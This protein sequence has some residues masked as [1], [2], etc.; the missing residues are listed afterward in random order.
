[1]IGQFADLEAEQ[2]IAFSNCNEYSAIN[3]PK[4]VCLDMITTPR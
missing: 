4:A 3:D 1:M 2:I